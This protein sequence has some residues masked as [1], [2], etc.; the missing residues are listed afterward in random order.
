MIRKWTEHSMY[1]HHLELEISSLSIPEKNRLFR[2]HHVSLLKLTL[3]NLDNLFPVIKPLYPVLGRPA[4]NQCE[5]LRSLILM[6]DFKKQ[7]ITDWAF[8][9]EHDDLLRIMCGFKKGDV[10]GTASYYDL[11]ERLWLSKRSKNR[12]KI[13]KFKRKPSKKYKA[14]SKLPNRKPGVVGRLVNAFQNGKLPDIRPEKILQDMLKYAVVETSA[15]LGLLGNTDSMA[16]SV[17]GS[18]YYAGSS[19][20]GTRVCNCKD[21]G[22]HRCDCA[23]KYADVDASWGWDSY[24]ECYFWG[25]ALF[26]VTAADSSNDL[27]IYLHSA[28]ASRHDGVSS[29]FAIRNVL[30]IYPQFKLHKFLADGAMDDY[31]IY[32][33]LTKLGIQPFIP[34][35]NNTKFPSLD[36][37]PE[38]LEFNEKGNPICRAGLPWVYW[39]YDR[40]KRRH[41]YRC[42]RA[43]KHDTGIRCFTCA[44]CNKSKSD[45]GPSIYLK[46]SNDVRLYPPVLRHTGQ[47]K[48]VFKRRSGVERTFKRIFEDYQVEAY[49]ARSRAVRFSLAVFAAINMHLDAWVQNIS[50]LPNNITSLMALA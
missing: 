42:P 35:P 46:S 32:E 10:P 37:Y 2:M 20:Y 27:P 25:D 28:Q 31:S 6:I 29:V 11:L 3:L 8:T 7:S 17:D 36:D 44:E 15:S 9:T 26:S 4:K 12:T 49:K 40:K 45:Y 38:I 18:T 5:L 22:L 19:P 30:R 48:Q 34:L 41:K 13:R 24:R 47:F 39:G 23:R 33:M 50:V 14:N 16:V 21:R 43:V 1:L